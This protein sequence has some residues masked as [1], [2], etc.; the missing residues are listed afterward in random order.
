[1]PMFIAG[2]ILMR[3]GPAL[4]QTVMTIAIIAF[5]AGVVFQIVTLPVEFNASTRAVALLTTQGIVT[6]EEVGGA[7]QVL[8][9]AALTYV[10]AA[11]QSIMM[12][13]Y[14]IMRSRR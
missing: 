10:A 5:A 6:Q 3:F 12:L 7:K 13:I 4:G 8:S 2:I 9:A 11:L 1:M 14:F